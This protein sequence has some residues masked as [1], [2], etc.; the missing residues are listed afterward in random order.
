MP[1]DTDYYIKSDFITDEDGISNTGQSFRFAKKTFDKVTRE[2]YQEDLDRE[3]TLTNSSVNKQS[4]DTVNVSEQ[5][6]VNTEDNK[7]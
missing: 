1:V 7:K 4:A 3:N 2:T 5:K 6:S